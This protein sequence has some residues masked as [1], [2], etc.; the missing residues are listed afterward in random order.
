MKKRFVLFIYLAALVICFIVIYIAPRAKETLTPTYIVKH[1]EISLECEVKAYIIRDEQVY[2]SSLSTGV[3]Q[4]IAQN[5]LVKS[6]TQII[7]LDGAGA[8]NIR[9]EMQTMIGK[10]GKSVVETSDGKSLQPGYVCYFVDGCEAKINANSLDQLRK[11][12]IQQ[13]GEAKAIP[14]INGKSAPGEPVF[15][16]IRNSEWWMLCYVDLEQAKDFEAGAK[17]QVEIAGKT[18]KGYVRTKLKEGDSYKIIIGSNIY[19]DNCMLLRTSKINIILAEGEGLI[20]DNTS[21]VNR[22]NTLGVIVKDKI[23][24]LHFKPIQVI[25]DN[26][27]KSAV[28]ED[29]FMN[30]EGNFVETLKTYDEVIRTP[31]SEQIREALAND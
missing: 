21:I 28:Y 1:G 26:G 29:I 14:T 17:C 9:P 12:N 22:D 23:G 11:D 13:H 8:K 15:K 6:G 24:Y 2:V 16:I 18:I 30:V 19:F 31:K 3:K 25:S 5:Q 4:I 20:I 10:L 27:T 7:K